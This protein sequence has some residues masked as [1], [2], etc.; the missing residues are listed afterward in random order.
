[1][2]FTGQIPHSCM[3]CTAIGCRMQHKKISTQRSVFLRMLSAPQ[4]W[5]KA[6]SD[7]SPQTVI[8]SGVNTLGC[9]DPSGRAWRSPGPDA[10]VSADL[11]LQNQ[12]ASTSSARPSQSAEFTFK[13]TERQQPA[14]RLLSSIS[15]N[16]EVDAAMGGGCFQLRPVESPGSSSGSNFTSEPQTAAWWTWLW[17]S[18]V[19]CCSSGALPRV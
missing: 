4:C 18:T 8:E 2:L 11:Q 15:I 19:M 13:Q 12:L 10:V 5:G 3:C 9:I 1:M 7:E 6:A 16:T 14:P 17:R